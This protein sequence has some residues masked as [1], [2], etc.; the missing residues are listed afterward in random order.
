MN[1]AVSP[2]SD[3]DGRRQWMRQCFWAALVLCFGSFTLTYLISSLVAG[4]VSRRW[5]KT[6]GQ[7]VDSRIWSTESGG[8]TKRGAS[9]AY[10]YTAGDRSYRNDI[11]RVGGAQ[12]WSD[13][14]ADELRALYTRGNSVP[15][16]HHRT[17]PWVSVLE[18]GF[19]PTSR[20]I[21]PFA[22]LPL[23]VGLILLRGR[24]NPATGRIR[25]DLG[26]SAERIP[27]A[28]R[29][30]FDLRLAMNRLFPA[31]ALAFAIAEIA[32]AISGDSTRPEGPVGGGYLGLLTFRG[33]AHGVVLM[34]VL[35]IA[36]G[37]LHALSS[38]TLIWIGGIAGLLTP[39]AL[40]AVRSLSNQTQDPAR[41]YF[42]EIMHPL[43][44]FGNVLP[45][46]LLSVASVYVRRLP[47][48]A[49]TYNTIR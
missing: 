33:L 8:S 35:F 36:R 4:A 1:V 23:A 38:R 6:T 37:L 29:E 3:P 11:V 17:R 44:A 48:F 10:R 30:P 24:P 26:R 39:L 40:F 13:A 27:R 45:L 49:E 47:R 19:S 25:V 18:P 28:M 7:I 43:L 12:V 16:Y 41:Y 42:G 14:E 2:A 34:L 32:L 15:V 31:Y 5:V 20:F 21:V 46:I 9:I 22:L